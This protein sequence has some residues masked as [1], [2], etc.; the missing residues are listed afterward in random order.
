MP[1]CRYQ[2][3]TDAVTAIQ[4]KLAQLEPETSRQERGDR[5]SRRGRDRSSTPTRKRKHSSGPGKQQQSSSSKRRHR[6]D[7]GR[8]EN[9]KH[10]LAM[11]NAQSG[12]SNQPALGFRQFSSN[13]SISVDNRLPEA[14]PLSQTAAVADF[15]ARMRGAMPHHFEKENIAYREFAPVITS[16]FTR[17]GKRKLSVKLRPV[18]QKVPSAVLTTLKKAPPQARGKLLKKLVSQVKARFRSSKFLRSNFVIFEMFEHLILF[19]AEVE[20][21]DN[22]GFA[23]VIKQEKR[24]ATAWFDTSGGTSPPERYRSA[25]PLKKCQVYARPAASPNATNPST[26]YT[27]MVATTV[28]TAGASTRETQGEQVLYRMHVSVLFLQWN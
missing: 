28:D 8:Q 12:S 23:T 16:R 20:D 9:Q 15:H 26:I 6:H 21:L 5:R 11:Q 27:S 2:D 22:A 25:N 10:L 19:G 4:R 1:S 13:S 3:L 24:G 14:L 17:G 18:S 7:L